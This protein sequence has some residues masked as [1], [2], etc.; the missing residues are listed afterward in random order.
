MGRVVAQR[1]GGEGQV[2]QDATS[3]QPSRPTRLRPYGLSHPPHEGEGESQAQSVVV[4][5]AFSVV[6]PF[7]GTLSVQTG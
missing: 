3:E 2:I 6:A 4:H 5:T 7:A 1:P